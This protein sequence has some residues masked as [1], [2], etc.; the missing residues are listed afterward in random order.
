[1]DNT[2]TSNQPDVNVQAINEVLTDFVVENAN[3]K[4]VIKQ[5]QMEKAILEESLKEVD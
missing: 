5:L 4:V 3:L 2:Q 1:M